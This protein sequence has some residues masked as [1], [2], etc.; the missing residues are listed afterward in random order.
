MEK[1]RFDPYVLYLSIIGTNDVT[2]LISKLNFESIPMA[3]P[4]YFDDLYKK[5]KGG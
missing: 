5:A 3:K 2:E 4:V 1:G